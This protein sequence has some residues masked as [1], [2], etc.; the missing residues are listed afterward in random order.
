MA[1]NSMTNIPFR[2]SDAYMR[3]WTSSPLFQVKV[4]V[5]L[6]FILERIIVYWTSGSKFSEMFIEILLKKM[7]AKYL[8]Q[9][10]VVCDQC[11]PS[12]SIT[13]LGPREDS[14]IARPH[15][16]TRPERQYPPVTFCSSFWYIWFWLT[17][18]DIAPN[19]H[20]TLNKQA[21]SLNYVWLVKGRDDISHFCS[22]H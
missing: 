16:Q 5:P 11:G 21:T 19:V 3:Q 14:N 20:W 9:K 10:C 15:L 13:Q 12:L 18:L 6:G 7:H 8:W 17:K 1:Y 4:S 2:L 22:L